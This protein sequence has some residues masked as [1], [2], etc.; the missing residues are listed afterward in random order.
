MAGPLN[1]AGYT[2]IIIPTVLQTA[3][4]VLSYLTSMTCLYDRYWAAD[5]NK[6]T[7]PICMFHVTDIKPVYTVETSKKRVILYEPQ[8]DEKLSAKEMSDQL[9]ENVMRSIIENSVKMPT[10]YTV[11]AIVPFQPV[12][13]YVAEGI[14][15]VSDMITGFSDLLG[16]AGFAGVWEGIF[17]S[18]FS[19]LK[20]ASTAAEFA[21]KL[22]GMD[23]VSYIN[24]NSLEAM[25]ES[26]RA[27]CMKMWTGYSYKFVQIT[28]MSPAKKGTE[29]DVFRVSM[30][31]QEKPVLAVSR[32]K[33]MT[34]HAI[35]R[36]WAAT[37]VSAVQG[38]LVTPLIG[39]TGVKNAAGG[40]ESG[41]SMIKGMLGV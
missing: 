26:C 4:D 12:G 36:N 40:G 14:K 25:A 19:L 8:G 21:G 7:L 35:N 16:G 6:V 17:S 34:K 33:N 30:T 28:S 38:A 18:V 5:P 27:L 15:T 10:T 37:A 41:V 23:G 22:P 29:D 2:G 11:E 24:M 32:P 13:R 39:L 9:R 31:L 20:V 1:G 3:A